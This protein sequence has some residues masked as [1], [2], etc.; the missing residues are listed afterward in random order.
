MRKPTELLLLMWRVVLA[1]T[2]LS[3]TGVA[4]RAT[5]ATPVQWRELRVPRRAVHSMVWDSRRGR[6]LMLGGDDGLAGAPPFQGV[7]PPVRG[8]APRWEPLAATGG[9]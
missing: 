1:A 3:I 2:L 7:R 8:S 9:G 4:L 5:P 6:A